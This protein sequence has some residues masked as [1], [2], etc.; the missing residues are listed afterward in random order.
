MP[1]L[2]TIT[3]Q[4]SHMSKAEIITLLLEKQQNLSVA[5]D[6]ARRLKSLLGS[7]NAELV[8]IVKSLLGVQ[9]RGSL[10]VLQRRLAKEPVTANNVAQREAVS[11]LLLLEYT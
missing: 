7:Q 1:E 3:S 11:Y 2:K 5:N 6:T 9:D 8:G 10:L 4:Y